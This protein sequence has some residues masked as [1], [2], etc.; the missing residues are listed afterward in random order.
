LLPADI[1]AEVNAFATLAT[2]GAT[3]ALAYLTYRLA[4]ESRSLRKAGSEPRIVSY[5]EPHPEGHGGVNFVLANIGQ[6]PAFDVRFAFVYDD[7]DFK[8]H[9]V[10]LKNDEVRTNLTVIPQG[11]KVAAL[12]GVGYVL[13]GS[14]AKGGTILKPFEVQ[15]SYRDIEGRS[16]A[17]SAKIDVRQFAG[18][19]GLANKPPVIAIAKSLEKIEQH[20]GQLPGIVSAQQQLVDS[21]RLSDSYIRRTKGNPSRPDTPEE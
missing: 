11:Q 20:L 4:W 15:V 6:G 1:V 8:A 17:S 5:L 13:F 21:T 3:V 14:D 10:L 7:E 16:R 12:F 19:P 2:A 9:D 18:L